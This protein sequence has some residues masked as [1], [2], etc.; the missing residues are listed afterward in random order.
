NAYYDFFKFPWFRY[1][2]YAPSKGYEWLARITFQPNRNL[3]TFFQIR[4][5]QKDRNLSDSG[6]PSLPYQ[7]RPLN[8]INGLISL[9]YQVSKA[10]FFRSRILFSRV[11]YNDQKSSGF[12]ILQ[13]AQY[14]F[15]KF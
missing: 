9:E 5:E 12:M 10:F 13:D 11:N 2:V 14:S 8:K 15:S 1:R 4:E 6:D 7:I 3:T